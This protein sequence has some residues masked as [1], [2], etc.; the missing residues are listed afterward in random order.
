MLLA[1]LLTAC[2]ALSL[3]PE[4]L[5]TLFELPTLTSLPPTATPQPI[6]DAT[7]DPAETEEA[8]PAD[9]APAPAEAAFVCEEGD[10]TLVEGTYPS[11][12]AGQDVSYRVYL[13]PCYETSGK[14]YPVLYMMH[15]LGQGMNYTQ[16]DDMG[17]DEAA[18]EGYASGALPPFIIVM[19]DGAVFLPNGTVV[20]GMNY[21]SPSNSYEYMILN[22]LM[23]AIE[24]EYCT[25]EAPEG[26]AIG[27]LSRGGFWAY[28]IAFRHPEL[29]SAVGGH[30]AYFYE[31]P[32]IPPANNPLNLATDAEGIEG[33]RLYFDHGSGDYPEVQ[34]AMGI[35]TARLDE[36]GLAPT[37]VVNA[38]GGHNEDYWAAH[39]GDYLSFYAAEWPNDINLLPPCS[40]P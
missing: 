11:A 36:R 31:S 7:T 5:P 22:E 25:W 3:T 10:G 33:L 27:G 17:L 18:A 37:Y 14:R 35:I 15:G 28:E 21:F 8:L 19:P 34:Q 2:S 30:S 38:V 24:A 16:W 9:P 32:E 40:R 29:F 26:R 4:P 23:P 6:A 20:H 1:F 12:I 13:P 39:T